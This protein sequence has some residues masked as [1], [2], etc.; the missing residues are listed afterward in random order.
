MEEGATPS[1]SDDAT[2]IASGADRMASGAIYD[3]G[4]APLMGVAEYND[5]RDD[6]YFPTYVDYF[7]KK[8]QRRA[9][10]IADLTKK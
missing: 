4:P 8:A 10:L 7:Q 5:P 1:E 9:I 2:D 6:A 3:L